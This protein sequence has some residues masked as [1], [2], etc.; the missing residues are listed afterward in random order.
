MTGVQTCAL[1]IFEKV[2]AA[3]PDK[4]AKDKDAKPPVPPPTK[5]EVKIDNALKPYTVPFNQKITTETKQVMKVFSQSV[6]QNQ[7]QTFWF[8]YTPVPKES[9]ENEVVIEQTVTRVDMDIEIGG[10]KIG[11]GKF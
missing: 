11:K 5:P 1:P 8:K 3:A 10:S 7:K 9:K 6:T 4:D 2:P